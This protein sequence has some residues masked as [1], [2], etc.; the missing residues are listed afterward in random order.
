MAGAGSGHPTSLRQAGANLTTVTVPTPLERQGNFSA[1][2]TVIYNAL[3]APRTPFPND[4]IPQSMLNPTALIAINAAP[5]ADVPGSINKYTNNNEV[6][7]QDSNN[8]S[9]R[10]DYVLSSA[11]TLFGRYSATRESDVTP[12]TA[13][14]YSAIGFALPQNGV[15]GS[16]G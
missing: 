9:I 7:K 13:P 10:T 8:Y 14:G 15:I 3:T 16:T 2:K 4:A 1:S 6:L 11:V 5:A 12:G